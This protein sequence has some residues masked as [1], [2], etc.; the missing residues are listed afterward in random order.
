MLARVVIC[1]QLWAG[2]TSDTTNVPAPTGCASDQR[3]LWRV[4]FWR[5]APPAGA[6]TVK[7][8][9][10][11]TVNDAPVVDTGQLPLVPGRQPTATWY[12]PAGTLTGMTAVYSRMPSTA[13]SVLIR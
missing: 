6:V 10:G 9:A 7:A 3:M 11:V 2:S 4:F 1:D 5:T 8:C 12:V 13:A